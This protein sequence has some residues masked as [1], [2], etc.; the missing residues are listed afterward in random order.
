FGPAAIERIGYLQQ[1]AGAVTEQRIRADRPAVI[2]VGEYLQRLTDDRVRFDASD[3]GNETHTAGIVFV[4]RIV[5]ALEGGIL[6]QTRRSCFPVGTRCAPSSLFGSGR[7][8]PGTAVP[9]RFSRGAPHGD[10]KQFWQ[11]SLNCATKLRTWRAKRNF[12]SGSPAHAL[13]RCQ[14]GAQGRVRIGLSRRG[15][16]LG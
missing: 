12:Q 1:D 7:E 9:C 5:E 11:G 6:G 4:A 15:R 16:L 10:W 14:R 2:E 13:E 3:M 8:S